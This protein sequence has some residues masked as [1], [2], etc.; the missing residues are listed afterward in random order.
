[1]TLRVFVSSTRKD[2]DVDCRPA[3]L[4]AFRFKPPGMEP[5]N[6][7]DWAAE[8]EPPVD[9]CQARVEASTYYLG[10]YGYYRGWV[11]PG[12]DS[13]SITEMEL[14]WAKLKKRPVA[15]FLPHPTEPRGNPFAQALEERAGNYQGRAELDAQREFLRRVGEGGTVEFFEDPAELGMRAVRRL[16][17]WANPL[18]DEAPGTVQVP[19]GARKLRESDLPRLGRADQVRVF[20]EALVRLS[21]PGAPGAACFLIH[22]PRHHG[23]GKLGERLR[24]LI[25]DEANGAARTIKLGFSLAGKHLLSTVLSAVSREAGGPA[26]ATAAEVAQQLAELLKLNYVVLDVARV[27]Q[28]AGGLAGFLAEFW[29]PIVAQLPPGLPYQLLCL[30][31]VEG[32]NI[33]N[34]KLERFVQDAD[35]PLDPS[36][37]VVLPELTH[38]TAAEVARFLRQ[39][40]PA[41]KRGS[42]A[43][44]AESL[45]DNSGGAPLL[46]Y[47]IL[48]DETYWL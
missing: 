13:R 11:P 6:M 39:F 10:V 38:F 12:G 34:P 44:I 15:I 26:T 43:E 22:G 37:L 3:V 24:S 29:Q 19:G 41:D 25:E 35:Q 31:S 30:T 28:Y 32:E 2:L 21:G 9:A 18:G 5:V 7:E 48:L 23:Q 27:E 16:Y 42:V 20:A 33:L 40:L 14:M 47:S 1:M 45:V 46:L 17:L 8:Y 4:R 36:R